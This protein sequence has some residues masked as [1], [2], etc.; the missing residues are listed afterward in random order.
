MTIK[1]VHGSLV[2]LALALILAALRAFPSTSP[3]VLAVVA[4]AAVLFVSGYRVAVWPQFWRRLFTSE[5]GV[6]S[7]LY[8][9]RGNGVLI[10]GSATPP[11][12]GQASVVHKQR[13]QVIMADSDTQALFTH[14]FGLDISAPTYLDPTIIVTAQLLNAGGTFL[15]GFTFDVTN[16]NVVKINKLNAL[17]SGGTF[18]VELHDDRSAAQI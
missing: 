13:A 8:F 3:F 10:N 11:T 6:V 7:V 16:T 14:N 2:T 12:A 17:G 18:I 9:V 15:T 5:L 4:G 1:T